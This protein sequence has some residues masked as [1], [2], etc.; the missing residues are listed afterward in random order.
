[1]KNPGGEKKRKKNLEALFFDMMTCWACQSRLVLSRHVG[2][3]LLYRIEYLSSSSSYILV[4]R[5]R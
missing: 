5:Y 2:S 1:L 3:C 4:A